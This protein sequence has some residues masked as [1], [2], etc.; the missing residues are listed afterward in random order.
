MNWKITGVKAMGASI[1]KCSSGNQ[2]Q[3]GTDFNERGYQG[4]VR[5]TSCQKL[6]VIRVGT[7][8]TVCREDVLSSFLWKAQNEVRI[9]TE[10]GRES[11]TVELLKRG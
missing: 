6:M 7:A 10:G 2:S 8:V 1:L 3:P 5:E 9:L 4:D 11:K